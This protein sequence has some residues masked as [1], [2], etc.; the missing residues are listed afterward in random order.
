[1]DH[2]TYD[3]V[4]DPGGRRREKG[5]SVD[6]IGRTVGSEEEGQGSEEGG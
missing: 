2:Q 6:E 4:G 3:R 5:E 1:V